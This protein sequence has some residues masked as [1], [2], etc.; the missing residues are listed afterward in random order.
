[1]LNKIRQKLG[2]SLAKYL[3][4]PLP[5]YTAFSVK[6]TE[7]LRQILQPGDIVLVEGDTRISVVIKYLTQSTWSHAALY[8]GREAGLK[9]RHGHYCEL[10]EADLEEGVVAVPLAKYAEFNTRICRSV[11]LG[12]GHRQQVVQ[13]VTNSLGKSYDLKNV[14]DLMRYLLPKPPVPTRFRRR[15]LA[16]GSGDP[17][18][19]I[20]ST[21]IA[22]AY[23]MVGYPILPIIEHRPTPYRYSE[24]EILHIR[25]HS[26]FAPRDFDLS[27]YFKIIKPT[28][29]EGFDFQKLQ[30]DEDRR[31]TTK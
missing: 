22:Q 30:W 4:R 12:E 10:I 11:G 3:S 26:L 19:A 13:F 25:H 8:V 20:C 16:V 17:T 6:S 24:Q 1:M 27:P 14:T 15:L 2:Q 23:Q 31:R 29:E 21:L 9:N 5:G 28:I 7:K 18:Q